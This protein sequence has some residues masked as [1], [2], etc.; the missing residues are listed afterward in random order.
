[1]EILRQANEEMGFAG[2]QLKTLRNPVSGQ[3]PCHATVMIGVYH[4]WSCAPRWPSS[5][6]IEADVFFKIHAQADDV[7]YLGFVNKE[8]DEPSKM[9]TKLSVP[10]REFF[11]AVVSAPPCFQ[12]TYY[13]QL[14]TMGGVTD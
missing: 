4:S 9:G 5:D 3:L 1:M 11:K 2:F 10:H 8:A 7:L 14:I 13:H 12:I 6:L